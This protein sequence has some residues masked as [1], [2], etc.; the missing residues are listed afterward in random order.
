MRHKISTP[1]L[2]STLLIGLSSAGILL[3]NKSIPNTYVEIEATNPEVMKINGPVYAPYGGNYYDSITATSGKA[4]RNQLTDLIDGHT[5]IGYKN[6][7]TVYYDS[8]A[9]PDGTVWDVYGDIDY[10]FS[11]TGQ[12]SKVGDSWNKEHGIP[13]SWFGEA[14]PMKSDAYHVYPTDGYINNWRGNMPLGEVNTVS[15][16][17]TFKGTYVEGVSKL[18][19]SKTSGI[20]GTVFEPADCYKGDFAR[21]YFYFVT[22]YASQCSSGACNKSSEANKVL[23]RDDTYFHLTKAAADLFYKWHKQDPVSQKEV[24]RCNGIQQ[25]QKNRNPYI[26][27]PEYVDAIWGDTPVQKVDPTAFDFEKDEVTLIK[28]E[29]FKLDVIP[30]PSNANTSAN[31]ASLDTNIARVND[32]L[33]TAVGIGTTYITATSKVVPTVSA[34]CKITVKELSSIS[35]SGTATQTD[36]FEGDIFNPDGITVTAKYTDDSTSIID[37]SQCTWVDGNTGI[38]YLS[39]GTTFVICNYQ[40]KQESYRGITVSESQGGSIEIDINSIEGLST[41]Y[42][43]YDWS[44]NNIEGSIYAYLSNKNTIQMNSSK[45]ANIIFNSNALPGRITK[46]TVYSATGTPKV[47]VRTNNEA[48]GKC[49]NPTTGTSGGQKNVSTTGVTWEFTTL[50]KYFAIVASDG[51]CYFSK[52]VIEYGNKSPDPEVHVTSVNVSP[53]YLS[54]KIND[55]YQLTTVVLPSNATDKSLRYVSTDD[56]IASVSNSGEIQAINAGTATISAISNDVPTIFGTCTV[57]VENDYIELDANSKSL[58]VGETTTINVVRAS[59]EVSWSCNDDS[60]IRIAGSNT[61]CLIE[62]LKPGNVTLTATVGGQSASVNVIVK[63]VPVP[64][65]APPTPKQGCGGE[66]TS[67]SAIIALLSIFGVGIILLRKKQKHE[68]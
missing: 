66:I 57:V 39:V 28:D 47:E 4:L 29:T 41:K 19:T 32:G 20:S 9:R 25:H 38:Q 63:E 37:N 35:L 26:D 49:K 34:S 50:D 51:V 44:S 8:D 23:T 67:T 55:S 60:I 21:S 10:D 31:W 36:Y 13:Q 40:N 68:K 45:S 61:S 5:V 12:Y 43:W 62:A 3:S 52:F 53:S 2:I 14:S 65:P 59:R 56:K 17:Y 1:I 24:N 30:T 64:P 46:V 48:F 58:L 54:L 42:A 33:V 22:R 16:S 15:K 6:L 7:E 11:D 18:G 27:H